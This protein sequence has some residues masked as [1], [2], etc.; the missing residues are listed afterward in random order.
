MTSN[1]DLFLEATGPWTGRARIGTT[2]RHG[3]VSR[4]PYATL[5][6]GR[7]TGDDPAAVTENR[8]RL[9]RALE[10][11]AEPAWLRQVHG[12]RVVRARASGTP[13][14]EEAD[15]AWTDEIGVVLA[16]LT[17]DCVPVVLHAPGRL[18]VAH[19]GWKGF[20][21]GV[22]E[23]AL[24]A[25]GAAGAETQAWLGPAV[26]AA[27]YVVGPEV[28]E[29]CLARCPEGT[30][31]FR[32][33][34]ERWTCDLSGLVSRRLRALGVGRVEATKHTTSEPD[35]YS[36]RRDGTTGRQ[37]TLAWLVAAADP[38]GGTRPASGVLRNPR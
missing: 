7:A 10:L 31:L 21:R 28:R 20:A 23:A 19:A 22:L 8:R 26:E 4:G 34:G 25:L 24:A 13:V 12:T 27:G 1:S 32:P 30:D 35:F 18:A 2:R 17:A 37:A 16:V 36:Y 15:G 38:V 14:L 11:P 9:V 5:N 33:R 6:L 29:A 3:G